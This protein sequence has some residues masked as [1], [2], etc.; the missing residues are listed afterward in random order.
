M[1]A[2]RNLTPVERETS[3]CDFGECPAVAQVRVVSQLTNN[4]L[5]LCLHHLRYSGL[6]RLIPEG[7][8]VETLTYH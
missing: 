4:D 6:E 8:Y 7:A 2:L 5:V 3:G 1:I